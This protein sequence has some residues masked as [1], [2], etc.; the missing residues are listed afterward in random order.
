MM[1]Y[2]DSI[3][4]INIFLFNSFVF[5]VFLLLFLLVLLVF[6]GNFLRITF[7]LVILW[8]SKKDKDNNQDIEKGDWLISAIPLTLNVRLDLLL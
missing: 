3:F 7:L 8:W 5:L 2:I 6:L 1:I 4:E